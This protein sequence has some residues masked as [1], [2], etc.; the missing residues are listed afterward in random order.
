MDKLK[1]LLKKVLAEGASFATL[2]I[3]DQTKITVKMGRVIPLPEFPVDAAWIDALY[4]ALF[5]R[6]GLALLAEQLVRSQF[7]IVNVGKVNAIADPRAP[8]TLYLFF[9]PNGEA[10]AQEQWA[11]LSPKKEEPQ[12]AM[13]VQ[14][15][16]VV[17]ATTQI[18]P[19]AGGP[20]PS[21]ISKALK[22]D[23][24]Q[25]AAPEE[26]TQAWQVVDATR[27]VDAPV[28]LPVEVL[29][30]RNNLALIISADSTVLAKAKEGTDHFKLFGF[31]TENDAIVY[32]VLD[33][34]QPKLII[35]DEKTGKF[36]TILK[37]IYD[38]DMGKRAQLTV[39]LLSKIFNTGDNKAIFAYSVDGIMSRDKL[40][41]M[42]EYL[43]S[44]D[45]ARKVAFQAWMDMST[46]V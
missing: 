46:K 41:G 20:G 16:P 8:K 11:N 25:A 36:E 15:E 45:T 21:T 33:R 19:P 43:V 6:E 37:K 18:T 4:K 24:T 44:I 10:L 29:T 13:K 2:R 23:G 7:N 30:N 9:P 32:N 3:G 26:A 14:L 35:L 22:A 39:L 12:G 17:D 5:P 40:E 42:K 27:S 34:F 31:V 28:N 1:L 38:M